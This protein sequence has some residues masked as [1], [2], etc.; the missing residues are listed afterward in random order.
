MIPLARSPDDISYGLKTIMRSPEVKP[1]NVVKLVLKSTDRAFR[2]VDGLSPPPEASI[3]ALTA[4]IQVLQAIAPHSQLR[5]EV[6]ESLQ[7]W[8][9]SIENWQ[10]KKLSNEAEV[11]LDD[12]LAGLSAEPET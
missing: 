2:D 11:A 10:K 9:P 5:G 4:R 3:T 7:Q 8:R 1:A 6:D 12:L